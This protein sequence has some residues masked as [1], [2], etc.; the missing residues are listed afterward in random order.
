MY[1]IGT[2]K[3]DSTSILDES[4]T[5][6][7]ANIAIR[8]RHLPYYCVVLLKLLQATEIFKT[9]DVTTQILHINTMNTGVRNISH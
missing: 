4:N 1:K 9:P 8:R 3:L 2:L 6:S 5:I 7:E